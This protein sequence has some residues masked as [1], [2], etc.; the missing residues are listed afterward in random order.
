MSEHMAYCTKSLNSICHSH[1]STEISN[2]TPLSRVTG[3][4]FQR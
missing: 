4:I 3:L 1:M 2:F